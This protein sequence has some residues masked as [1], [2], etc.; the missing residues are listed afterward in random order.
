MRKLAVGGAHRMS[1]EP[2]AVRTTVHALAEVAAG[3]PLRVV[4]VAAV[5]VAG[6]QLLRARFVLR[7]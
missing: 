6:E 7:A 4:L 2:R 5:V 1:V 3:G